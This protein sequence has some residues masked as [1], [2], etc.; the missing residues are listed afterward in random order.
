MRAALRRRRGSGG[1]STQNYTHTHIRRERET[2]GEQPG[3]CARL[4]AGEREWGK[5][6]K[7]GEKRINID[8]FWKVGRRGRRTAICSRSQDARWR[9]KKKKNSGKA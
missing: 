8:R 1:R 4:V 6:E 9:K 3:T 2:G 7:F 5:E